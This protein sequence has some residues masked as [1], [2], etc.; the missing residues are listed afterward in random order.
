[1][2]DSQEA[3]PEKK[4]ATGN[5]F[6]TQC[7]QTIPWVKG[8]NHRIA[9]WNGC[10]IKLSESVGNISMSRK[11]DLSLC[12]HTVDLYECRGYGNIVKSVVPLSPLLGGEVCVSWSRRQ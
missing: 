12:L 7:I 3:L 8:W 2:T 10:E 9:R 6:G 1:M 4:F 11:E 5:S